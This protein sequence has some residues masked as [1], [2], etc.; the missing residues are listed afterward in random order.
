MD[1][2]TVTEWNELNLKENTQKTIGV[3]HIHDLLNNLR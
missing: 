2:H 1:I 3:L